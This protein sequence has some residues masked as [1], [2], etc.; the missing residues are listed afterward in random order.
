MKHLSAALAG[1]LLST[2]LY[3]A[4]AST[5]AVEFCAQRRDT[6]YL[7]DL[8]KDSDNH[9]AFRNHGGLIGGGVC[10]W[11]SRFTRNALHLAIYR[12]D[13]ARPS[14][15]QMRSII[16]DIRRG[17]NVVIIPGFRNLREF[18]SHRVAAELIQ[19]EL[20]AWQRVDGFVRQQ[21]IV[22]LMG[23]SSVSADEL[24][25]KMD[26]LYETVVLEKNITYQKLQ[27]PGVVAHAWLVVDVDKTPDGY[28][29]QVHDSNYYGIRN[30]SYR[31]GMTDFRYSGFGNF[32]PYTEREREL[33]G[34]KSVASRFCR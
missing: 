11:H 5:S 27:L 7:Q 20:E 25:K 33:R 8:M 1:L 14:V 12:P 13:M 21:W 9:L 4:T 26:D 30:W 15:A 10:W 28:E 29:L 23:S 22:G 3:A 19:K 17:N 16:K 32:V 31:E 6:N 24:S 2:S 18:S 34:I